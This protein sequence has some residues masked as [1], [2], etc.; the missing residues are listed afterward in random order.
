M[1]LMRLQILLVREQK[2]VLRK[3]GVWKTETVQKKG[4]ALEAAN[5]ARKLL[6]RRRGCERAPLLPAKATSS[7]GISVRT[8]VSLSEPGGQGPV[9][10]V[11]WHQQSY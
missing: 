3:R 11:F 7:Q 4:G 5:E 10:R 8:F 1:E 2:A 9:N 6:N